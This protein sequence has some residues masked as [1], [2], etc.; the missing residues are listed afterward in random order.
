MDTCLNRFL[1]AQKY[2]YE[3]ALEEIKKGKKMSH[4]MWYIFPQIKGLGHSET[5]IYYEIKSLEEAKAYLE[6]DVLRNRLLQLTDE[7]LLLTTNNPI[8]IFGYVDAMKLKSCMT[9][10]E[11][12]SDIENF[13]KVLEKFYQG[14][15][16]EY[17]ITICS[18]MQKDKIK[19]NKT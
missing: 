18:S 17:T 1:E 15:R 4:W 7:L 6:H 19:K 2:S 10:F 3:T 11:Y 8:E 13:G 16:D 9:L 5:A 14:L 12:I